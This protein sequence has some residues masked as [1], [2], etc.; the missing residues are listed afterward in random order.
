MIAT[1]LLNL[2]TSFLILSKGPFLV[3]CDFCES[4]EKETGIFDCPNVD[5]FNVNNE[6]NKP[7]G[8][9]KLDLAVRLV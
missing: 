4:H 2:V 9:W 7:D 1:E 3:K 5:Y 6:F 8:T